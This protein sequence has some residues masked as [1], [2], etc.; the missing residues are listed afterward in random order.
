VVDVLKHVAENY[1]PFDLTILETADAAEGWWQ[2]H[3]N[4]LPE[5]C[6]AANETMRAIE[7]DAEADKGE[8]RS[9][10]CHGLLL[11][12]LLLLLLCLWW[13]CCC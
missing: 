5:D 4:E 10:H 1:R 13:L 7:A 8:Q 6:I 11:I 9:R 3:I 12:L 2:C